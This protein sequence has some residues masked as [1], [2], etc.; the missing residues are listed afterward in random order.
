M[1]PGRPTRS[2]K[3]RTKYDNI[4]CRHW[5]SFKT[6]DALLMVSSGPQPQSALLNLP[7]DILSQIFM[8]ADPV[9][10]IAMAF[11]CR[12]LLAIGNLRPRLL[13]VPDLHY[14][15]EAWAVGS[16]Q[17]VDTLC[18]CGNANALLWHVRPFSRH[19]NREAP[20]RRLCVDCHRWFHSGRFRKAHW[21]SNGQATM[22]REDFQA[23][24]EDAEDPEV[25]R[26]DDGLLSWPEFWDEYRNA[27]RLFHQGYKRQCPQCAVRAQAQIFGLALSDV[28]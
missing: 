27:A 22:R 14:H 11:S 24:L 12:C 20:D 7:P 6:P 3:N 13:V 25:T 4:R 26:G 19:T 28:Y 2:D 21:Q 9:T 17:N 1:A 18:G 23:W 10:R 15:R 8:A 5:T 16:A